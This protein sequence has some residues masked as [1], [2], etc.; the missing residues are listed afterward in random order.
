MPFT[1]ICFTFEKYTIL[2]DAFNFTH[3]GEVVGGT[4]FYF[5]S[6]VTGV[7]LVHVQ[8]GGHLVHSYI[9]KNRGSFG[10]KLFKKRVIRYI[11]PEM[12]IKL[13]SLGTEL[14]KFVN[15]SV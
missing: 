15:L 9:H 6:E 1:Y 12:C 5:L 14:H 11:H 4:L 2:V 7:C 3:P 8:S 13:G 10:T